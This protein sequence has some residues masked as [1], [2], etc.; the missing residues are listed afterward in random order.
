MAQARLSASCSSRK[1]VSDEIRL[2]KELKATQFYARSLI[3]ASLD[4]L[5]TISP[6]GKITDVNAAS[7]QVTGVEREQLMGTTFP[8]TSPSPRKPVKASNGYSPKGTSPITPLPFITR[9]A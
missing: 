9:T 8:T 4:L 5:G 7:V 1:N 2:T 6:E 3:E